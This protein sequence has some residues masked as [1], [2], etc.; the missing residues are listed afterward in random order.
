M[1]K[2]LA[3]TVNQPFFY[4]FLYFLHLSHSLS[5]SSCPPLTHF[6][7]FSLSHSLSTLLP[8]PCPSRFPR[9]LFSDLFDKGVVV[10]RPDWVIESCREGRQLPCERHSLPPFE[11]LRI[12]I[13]GLSLGMGGTLRSVMFVLVCG[14]CGSTAVARRCD[15]SSVGVSPAALLLVGVFAQ[16]PVLFWPPAALVSLSGFVVGVTV[17]LRLFS[18]GALRTEV[19]TL[20]A[21][22]RPA[23]VCPLHAPPP[24][25]SLC[26]TRNLDSS[27]TQFGDHAG[28]AKRQTERR[29]CE[30]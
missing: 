13:T 14:I 27:C 30:R 5:N 7:F 23:F 24:P 18:G 29:S 8:S 20:Y 9:R 12:T 2:H 25:C 19:A 4:C 10:V 22:P 16:T 6:S 28:V 21:A 11:G 17:A 15:M 26:M 1:T 3:F